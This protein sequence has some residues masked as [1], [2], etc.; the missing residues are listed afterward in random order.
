ML[1]ELARFVPTDALKV[2]LVLVLSF[3]IGLERE[4]HKQRE[5][6]FAFGGIRVFPLLGMLSYALALVSGSGLLAWLLGLLVVG[7]LMVASYLHRVAVTKGASMA[8]ELSALGTYVIGALVYQE[9]FWLAGTIGVLSLLL[10]EL[11][12]A[13]EGLA[14]RVAPNE[15]LTAAKFLILTVVILPI[16]PDQDLTPFR[17]NPFKTWL[18]VVAVSGISYASYLLQKALRGR[19][20]VFVAG[21]I[22][23]AYSS[24]ATTIAFARQAREKSSPNLFTGSIL[25]ACGM[26]Y[27][28][29][30]VLIAFFNRPL[31]ARVAPAFALLA[32]VGGLGSWL[33]ARQTTDRG[34]PQ[35]TPNNPLQLKAA[36]LFALVFMTI[37][38]LTQWAST[39]LGS[40][41]LYALAALVGAADVDPFILGLAHSSKAETS[42]GTASYAAAIAAA[43]NNLVKGVYGY[44]F[45]DRATGR[46]ILATLAAF[47]GLGVVPL[48]WL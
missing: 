37:L 21:L 31:A 11:K 8:G 34:E 35:H 10:L 44:Y 19:G 23:G 15:I 6:T 12:D 29:L 17:I 2:G 33:I 48:V 16:L 26:M 47:A 39:Y 30:A 28:R 4:E 7:A 13:L 20:G 32:L 27:A 25:A 46:R 5:T 43:S 24:T 3:F 38:V 22:G 45:A 9:H 14:K 36:F 42:L 18:V 41:G 40:T 1:Q